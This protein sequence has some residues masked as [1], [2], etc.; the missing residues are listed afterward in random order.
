MG[1][2]VKFPTAHYIHAMKVFKAIERAAEARAKCPV[3]LGQISE[4]QIAELEGRFAVLNETGERVIPEWLRW[5]ARQ[6]RSVPSVGQG[7]CHLAGPG[8]RHPAT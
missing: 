6:A 8:T 1:S 4:A 7:A 2:Q 5:L 3:W